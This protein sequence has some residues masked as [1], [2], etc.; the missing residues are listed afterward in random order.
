MC[1]YVCVCVCVCVY[2]FVCACVCGG[3]GKGKGLFDTNIL[4]FDLLT[5]TR[6]AYECVCTQKF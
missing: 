2:V 5:N 3:G 6:Q 1:V 4:P